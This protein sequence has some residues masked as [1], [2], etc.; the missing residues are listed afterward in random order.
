MK[1]DNVVTGMKNEPSWLERAGIHWFFV[2]T[3]MGFTDSIFVGVNLHPFAF[4]VFCI[5][6]AHLLQ[7]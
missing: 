7:L 6:N 1:N 5:D 4:I 3:G 2:V